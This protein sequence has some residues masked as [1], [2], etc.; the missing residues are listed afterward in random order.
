MN[1]LAV[2]SLNRCLTINLTVLSPAVILHSFKKREGEGLYWCK[3][4]STVDHLELLG[5]AKTLDCQK[6]TSTTSRIKTQ[7]T[8]CNMKVNSMGWL[9]SLS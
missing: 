3:N 8:N 9:H 5:H 6:T 7:L 4:C 1:E 2:R